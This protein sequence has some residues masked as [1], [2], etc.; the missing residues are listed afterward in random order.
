MDVE[1]LL[2]KC[3]YLK[4]GLSHCIPDSIVRVSLVKDEELIY[5][6]V[7]KLPFKYEHRYDVEDFYR[8]N[9]EQI[10]TF[11]MRDI[12]ERILTV[13]IDD[14]SYTTVKTFF[15]NKEVQEEIG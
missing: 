1:R 13:F 11:L 5:I 10:F 12:I 7:Y 2:K 3:E 15:A 8:C 4:E 6:Y 14:P 9:I